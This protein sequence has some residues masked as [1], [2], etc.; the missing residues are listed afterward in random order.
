MAL[1]IKMFRTSVHFQ[2]AFSSLYKIAII[3]SSLFHVH[4]CFPRAFSVY[5]TKRTTCQSRMKSPRWLVIVSRDGRDHFFH[6]F[7]ATFSSTFIS[8]LSFFFLLLF[9][10][11]SFTKLN[12]VKDGLWFCNEILLQNRFLLNLRCYFRSS[13]SSY[14][15][16][17]SIFFMCFSLFA[18]PLF[19]EFSD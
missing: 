9:A 6:A 13:C 1:A 14:L 3:M 10:L 7:R 5:H 17:G 2:F 8:W 12:Y 16:S 19:N 18:N 4:L 15:L 11:N